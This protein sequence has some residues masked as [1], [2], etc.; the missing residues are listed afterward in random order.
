[1]RK[2][3]LAAMIN[4]ESSLQDIMQMLSPQEQEELKDGMS[5]QHFKKMKHSTKK[6]K[7]LKCFI[8]LSVAR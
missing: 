3:D 5:I 8:A 2:K 6:V 7:C 4:V 1:M